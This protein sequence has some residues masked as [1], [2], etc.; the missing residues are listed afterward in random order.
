[1]VWITPALFK[2]FFGKPVRS[3]L[4]GKFIDSLKLCVRG[5]AGGMGYPKYGGVGGKGGNVYVVAKEGAQLQQIVKKFPRKLIAAQSGESSR[6]KC[7]LGQPGKDVHLN[8]PVGIFVIDEYGR[9]LGELNENGSS[10][11]V[12]E[13]S[14]GGCAQ[15]GFN[16]LP[17]VE[18]FITLDL[19][20]IADVGLVGF[21]NAGKSSL[22]RAISR[23]KPKVASY[24]FTTLKPS[25]GIVE[26]EDLRKFSVADLPGLIEGAHV[27]IGLGHNF[28]KHVERTR[29]LLFVV[30]AFG[31]SLSPKHTHR[32][33]LETIVLLNKE[34][35]LYRE[36]LMEKPAALVINK[37]DLP[38]AEEKFEEVKQNLKNLPEIVESMAEEFRPNKL[39]NFEFVI[40]LSAQFGKK[41]ELDKLK[42]YLRDTMEWVYIE[43]LG[44]VPCSSED[45]SGRVVWSKKNSAKMLNT[46]EEILKRISERGKQLV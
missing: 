3:Y 7:I 33:C 37:L 30:D 39:L 44:E 27:N 45:G 13:G 11:L 28:L 16:G 9:K 32:S 8:V 24:P 46:P 12:A 17:G 5:G 4:K 25:L 14:P 40:G 15:T 34:L 36:D 1:M 41:E 22:L 29:V 38:N 2:Q 42:I 18:K 20:L 43:G 31:F 35:E 26:F 10:L 23:A 21:P 19:R 6:Q